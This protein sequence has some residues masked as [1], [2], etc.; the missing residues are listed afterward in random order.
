MFRL[1]EDYVGSIIR[2]VK[3]FVNLVICGDVD[4]VE[5]VLGL[6]IF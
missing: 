3:V 2:E 5:R 1:F 6:F 4:S